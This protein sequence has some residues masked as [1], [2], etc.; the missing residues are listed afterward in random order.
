MAC[1]TQFSNPSTGA[2]VSPAARGSNIKSIT[3]ISTTAEQVIERSKGSGKRQNKN[4]K[5]KRSL[6]KTTQSVTVELPGW[7][8]ATTV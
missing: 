5:K 2:Q 4:Q 6:E 1:N 7:H 8:R 3:L